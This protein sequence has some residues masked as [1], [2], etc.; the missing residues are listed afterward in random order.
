M[1]ILSTSLYSAWS[2][3]WVE[4][5]HS[6]T[7]NRC[8]Q[9][10]RKGKVKVSHPKKS[11]KI[12]HDWCVMMSVGSYLWR[13]PSLASL[14]HHY[15]PL[16]D[17]ID[18]GIRRQSYKLNAHPS[19][20]EIFHTETLRWWYIYVEK[21]KFMSGLKIHIYQVFFA[22]YYEQISL[23]RKQKDL[24]LFPWPLVFKL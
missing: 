10:W 16:H 17:V 19:S 24:S 8:P 5:I 3:V 6:D 23:I 20:R 2:S 14:F 13:R 15:G 9:I 18:S 12:S 4:L 7:I 11:W 21:N 1:Y 22:L